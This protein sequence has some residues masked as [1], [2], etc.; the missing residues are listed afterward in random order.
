MY[1]VSLSFRN[2]IF[3]ACSSSKS[4][5]MSSNFFLA[6][7]SYLALTFFGVGSISTSF[8]L[9]FLDN[10]SLSLPDDDTFVETWT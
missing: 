8:V 5:Q 9:I 1:I 3:P 2:I 10:G 7:L 6:S 4:A